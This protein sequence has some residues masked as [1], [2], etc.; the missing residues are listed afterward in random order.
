ME[1]L[2][3]AV[4]CVT[5]IGFTATAFTAI[6][7]NPLNK[8]IHNLE[9]LIQDMRGDLKHNE[10]KRQ[11]MDKRIVKTE[12]SVKSAHHRINHI[13]SYLDMEKSDM[14]SINENTKHDSHRNNR[15]HW[16]GN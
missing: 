9:Q 5:I 10:E 13:E 7:L 16:T 2:A 8:A 12:E 6:V 1:Y 15:Q 14:R 3:I 11:E 4:S